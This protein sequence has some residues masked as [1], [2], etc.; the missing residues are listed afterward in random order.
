MRMARRHFA[1]DVGPGFFDGRH[2]IGYWF[3]EVDP[4][5]AVD[6][7]RHSTMSTR[8]GP[9]PTTWPISIRA[10]GRKPVFTV[11]LPL[12]VPVFSTRRSRAQRLGLPDRFVFLF[13]FDFLSV[14]AAEESRSG[15][16]EA[17]TQRVRAR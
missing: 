17:F 1:R 6:A 5:P 14:M 2:T 9:R 4:L 10:A 12:P 15:L 8:C 13:V 11:P 3:W 7:S 16:I